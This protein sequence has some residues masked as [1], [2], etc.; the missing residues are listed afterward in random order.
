MKTNLLEYNTAV[1]SFSKDIND[2][3]YFL[4]GIYYDN[5]LV[6]VVEQASMATKFNWINA[7]HFTK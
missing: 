2:Y 1:R 5:F 7:E 6:E 3:Y 4:D